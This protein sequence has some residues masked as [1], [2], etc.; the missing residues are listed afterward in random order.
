MSM[1]VL[2]SFFLS[3]GFGLYAV[4]W[5]Y[6]LLGPLIGIFPVSVWYRDMGYML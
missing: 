1:V 3:M 4:G 5:L 2:F 6:W